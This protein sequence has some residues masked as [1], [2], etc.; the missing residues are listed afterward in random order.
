MKFNVWRVAAITSFVLALTATMFS[1]LSLDGWNKALR[2]NKA[3]SAAYVE[4][5]DAKQA[6]LTGLSVEVAIMEDGT[7]MVRLDKNDD[8][9]ATFPK[10]CSSTWRSL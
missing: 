6:D 7:V 4:L 5:E 3:L 8:Y 2:A 9:T 1:Y 10:A